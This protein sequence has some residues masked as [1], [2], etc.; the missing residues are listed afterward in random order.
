MYNFTKHTFIIFSLSMLL[1]AES[2]TAQ[3]M[4]LV[5]N[6]STRILTFSPKQ[7]AL[8]QEFEEAK[9]KLLYQKE[10][11][12]QLFLE[13]HRTVTELDVR[14]LIEL[15]DNGADANMHDDTGA[16]ALHV[17]SFVGN[18]DAVLVLLERGANPNAECTNVIAGPTPLHYATYKAQ[19]PKAGVITALVRA[20][21]SKKV[22]GINGQ[23]PLWQAMAHQDPDAVLAL[24]TTLKRN[25]AIRGL[26]TSDEQKLEHELNELEQ[27]LLLANEAGLTPYQEAERRKRLD[28]AALVHPCDVLQYRRELID[29]LKD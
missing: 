4:R 27:L 10:L 6:F 14:P 2:G 5:R 20:G 18:T 7:R 9:G 12:E 19:A 1:F 17:A 13:S 25:C 28:I 29:S 3:A 22:Q 24:L 8:A 23:T 11:D 21:A 26:L 15:L 16:T